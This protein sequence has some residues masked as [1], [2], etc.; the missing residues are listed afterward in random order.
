MLLFYYFVVCYS[1]FAHTHT[2]TTAI[3][4]LNVYP[5]ANASTFNMNS[6]PNNID[7]TSNMNADDLG[8]VSRTNNVEL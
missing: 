2:N 5:F 1:D 4:S 3:N 7:V 8:T 6:N